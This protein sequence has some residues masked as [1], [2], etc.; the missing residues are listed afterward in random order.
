VTRAKLHGTDSLT[1]MARIARDAGV[2]E[3]APFAVVVDARR[4]MLYF[5]LYDEAA[6]K[7]E[8]PL[9]LSP[10]DAALLLPAGRMRAVGSGA[11]MLAEAAASVGRHVEPALPE[12]QP[13]ATAL[14]LI[15]LESRETVPILRP[16]YLRPPDAR[17]QAQLVERR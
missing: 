4:D 7:R 6:R 10:S 17:P 9:L 11:A 5:G 12:L 8:G 1:V 16:L 2:T 3:D 15:A 13:N 14:A